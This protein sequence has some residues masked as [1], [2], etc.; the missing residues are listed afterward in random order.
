MQEPGSTG[1]GRGCCESHMTYAQEVADSQPVH[2]QMYAEF[3]DSGV[4]PSRILLYL[5]NLRS[6]SLVVLSRP[7]QQ[8]QQL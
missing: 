4:T 7:K 2:Y 5:S 6:K 3:T 8:Q 1:A